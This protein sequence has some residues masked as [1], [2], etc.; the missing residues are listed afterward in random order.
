MEDLSSELR[1]VLGSIDRQDDCALRESSQ[2]DLL[3]FDWSHD[4]Q[5]FVGVREN[6]TGPAGPTFPI[7]GM[8]PFQ[9]FSKIWDGDII[10][11]IVDETNKYAANLVSSS[12]PQFSRMRKWPPIK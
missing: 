1:E 5:V 7:E 2:E 3:I 11:L 4:P 9:V 12:I 10:N 6:F 8:S